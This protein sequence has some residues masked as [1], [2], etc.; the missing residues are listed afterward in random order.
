[1]K[2]E[3]TFDRAHS[4]LVIVLEQY[5]ALISTRPLLCVLG[6]KFATDISVST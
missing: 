2:L 1:M 4:D 5:T 3:Y 6:D